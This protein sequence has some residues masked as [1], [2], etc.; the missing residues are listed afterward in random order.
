MADKE[1][2]PKDPQAI[3][4]EATEDDKSA[5]SDKSVDRKTQMSRGRG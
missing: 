3:E 5:E 4:A 2:K 1:I